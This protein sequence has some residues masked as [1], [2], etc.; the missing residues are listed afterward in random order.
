[1]LCIENEPLTDCDLA[2]IAMRLSFLETLERIV[3]VEQMGLTGNGAF[4]YLSEVPYLRNVAP[5][6]QLDVLLECWSRLRSPDQHA[7]TLVDES[8]VYAACEAASR[9]VDCDAD[10]AKQ[11]LSGGPRKLH[12]DLTGPLA[13]ELRFL[14]LCLPNEGHF[15]LLSQFQDVDP[16]AGAKLKMSFGLDAAACELMFDV[17]GRWHV[18]PAF[19][20]NSDGLL[21]E[22]E[23]AQAIEILGLYRTASPR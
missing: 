18:S 13:D 1:M 12:V 3:L 2:Y 6:V 23:S 4:G 11:Y 20:Q 8:I 10:F 5:Q 19:R 21:S 7:A 15:L 17:L 22:S 9:I 16:D 14:H